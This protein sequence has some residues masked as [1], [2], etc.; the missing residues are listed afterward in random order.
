MQM[1]VLLLIVLM[2]VILFYYMYLYLLYEGSGSSFL[3]PTI[4]LR[5]GKATE[6]QVM[7]MRKYFMALPGTMGEI[8]Y[9]L[10]N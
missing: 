1:T 10:Y 4:L 7:K 8:L 2:A 3:L 9:I 5:I 6:S